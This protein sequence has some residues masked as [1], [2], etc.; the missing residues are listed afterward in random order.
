ME[1]TLA[2]LGRALRKLA[3][4]TPILTGIIWGSTAPVS[5][6]VL[7]YISPWELAFYRSLVASLALLLIIRVRQ[8]HESFRIGLREVILLSLAGIVI[9]WIIYNI[10]L[11]HVNANQVGLMLGSYPLMTALIAYLFVG[12][13]LTPTKYLGI[14]VGFVGL[15]VFFSDKVSFNPDLMW[16][17]GAFLVMVA[18]L[19]WAVYAAALKKIGLSGESL[20]LTERMFLVS[21]PMSFVAVLAAQGGIGLP[22][23][24]ASAAGVIW[25]GLFPSAL[26]YYLFNVGSESV[27]ATVMATSGLLIPLTSAFIAYLMLGETFTLIEIVGAILIIGGLALAFSKG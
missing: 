18:I 20:E 25:L 1:P 15:A 13:K 23:T 24:P 8:P 11:L 21:V 5:K 4:A 7:F 6:L 12:E 14:V 22:S 26:A 19:L 2:V 16:I 10:G 3:A 27:S 9:P 17:F